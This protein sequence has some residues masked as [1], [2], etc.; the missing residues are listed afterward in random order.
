MTTAAKIQHGFAQEAC[1][2]RGVGIVASYAS[3]LVKDRPVD[4]AA[5]KGFIHRL[6]MTLAACLD[7]P[8]GG[9]NRIRRRIPLVALTTHTLGHGV[10]HIVFKE[11]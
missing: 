1:L 4:V 9:R 10:V 6:L 11:R 5:F 7:A 8:S 2:A 3:L